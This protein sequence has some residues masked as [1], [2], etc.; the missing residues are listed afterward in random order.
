MKGR[1]GWFGATALAAAVVPGASA[2][3]PPVF[4]TSVEAVYVDV[5]VSRGGQPNPAGSQALEKSD[6]PTGTIPLN[7]ESD[8]VTGE[9]DAGQYRALVE[10]YFKAITA[11]KK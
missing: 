6:S 3:A 10:Q 4:S 2:Q 5:F 9:S 11:P 8:S 1:P 7:R